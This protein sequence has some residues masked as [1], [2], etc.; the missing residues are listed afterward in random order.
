MDHGSFSRVPPTAMATAYS[1]SFRYTGDGKV[2]PK[3]GSLQAFV[4]VRAYTQSSLYHH[5]TI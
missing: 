2:V 1:R 3:L 5:N 4:Q